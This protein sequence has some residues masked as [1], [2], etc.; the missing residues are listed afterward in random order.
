MI[1]SLHRHLKTH[2][3]EQMEKR[4]PIVEGNKFRNSQ[5]VVYQVTEALGFGR[6][7]WVVTVPDRLRQ[8]QFPRA[9]LERMERVA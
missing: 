2:G 7:Y 5:G 1:E 4:T 9:S 6:G 3:A 8:V